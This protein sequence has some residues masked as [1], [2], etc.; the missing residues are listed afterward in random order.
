MTLQRFNCPHCDK[1][2]K[3][4][5]PAA[6]RTVTCP[7]CR[8]R[9]VVPG[10]APPAPPPPLP[11]FALPSPAEKPP[12]QRPQPLG[13]AVLGFLLNPDAGDPFAH[14]AFLYVAAVNLLQYLFGL[15]LSFLAGTDG[16]RYLVWL[17]VVGPPAVAV[18]A[19]LLHYGNMPGVVQVVRGLSWLACLLQP[20]VGVLA[21]F[22]C[23]ILLFTGMLA[24]FALFT[25]AVLAYLYVGFLTGTLLEPTTRFGQPWKAA[26]GWGVAGCLVGYLV[27]LAGL[28]GLAYQVAYRWRPETET[29]VPWL[30]AAAVPLGLVAIVAMVRRM[31]LRRVSRI[32]EVTWSSPPEPRRTVEPSFVL[33][34]ND[35]S[36][37]KS[38]LHVG[39]SLDAIIA[40]LGPPDSS[41]GGADLLAG[42]NVRVTG[43][44]D[45]LMGRAWYTWRRPEGTY[46]LTIQDGRLANIQNAPD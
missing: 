31:A 16:L 8:Q 32:E 22:V 7:R 12:R 5:G 35:A 33:P 25:P 26:G 37:K 43:S 24:H 40:L 14:Y 19:L 15:G 42:R 27:I 21:L 29:L 9:M 39:M 28:V 17:A 10:E 20:L 18:P 1:R 3:V 13:A 46:T 2:M 38:Q 4:E 41:A 36:S 11:D 30:L 23:L 44:T 6:G 45:G 34:G